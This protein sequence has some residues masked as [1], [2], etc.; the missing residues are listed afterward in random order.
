MI[1]LT[2]SEGFYE[3][4]R[5]HSLIWAIRCPHVCG[6]PVSTW[7]GSVC[8]VEN[9]RQHLSGME[10]IFGGIFALSKFLPP[11]WKEVCGKKKKKKKKK[12]RKESPFFSFYRRPEGYSEQEST[13]KVKKK[14]KKKMNL[15]PTQ[16]AHDIYTTSY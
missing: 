2:D 11:F 9:P 5:K 3:V 8:Y 12:K 7:H 13:V 6:R 1:L 4:V 10:T 14:K 16:R 15:L